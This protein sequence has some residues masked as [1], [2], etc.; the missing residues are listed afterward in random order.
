MKI[1]KETRSTQTKTQ[2]A[3]GRKLCFV[4]IENFVGKSSFTY[5]EADK[6]R[7]RIEK[8]AHLT[9]SDLVVVGT[10]A[11]GNFFNAK[12]A[13]N[14]AQQ[15]WGKGKNGGD[16]ALLETVA[17]YK[18]ENFEEVLFVTGDG[19]FA[20]M[21]DEIASRGVIVTV[22]YGRGWCSNKLKA[23]ATCIAA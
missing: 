23:V 2:T 5:E 6:A 3:E 7:K 1:K 15:V 20:G 13:W 18:V 14:G 12:L 9:D 19:I 22:I 10:S 21:V 11:S 8:V 17:D 4:D 16:N